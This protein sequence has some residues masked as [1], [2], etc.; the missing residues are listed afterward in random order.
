M[1]TYNDMCPGYQRE[2]YAPS[3]RCCCGLHWEGKM[4]LH[5]ARGLLIPDEMIARLDARVA[6]ADLVEQRQAS[7]RSEEHRRKVMHF[8]RP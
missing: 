3:G 1:I 6:A 2:H 8:G 7:I 4:P 5:T